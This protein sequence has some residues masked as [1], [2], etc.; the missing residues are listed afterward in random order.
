MKE[1]VRTVILVIL[2]AI[3]IGF[4]IWTRNAVETNFLD[5]LE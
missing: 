5:T 1:W 3:A 2:F 4:I